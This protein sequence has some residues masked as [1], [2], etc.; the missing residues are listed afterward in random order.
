MRFVVGFICLGMSAW[1]VA[2]GGCLPLIDLDDNNRNPAPGTTLAVSVN[3]PTTNRTVPEGTAIAIRWLAVNRTGQGAVATISA[4]RLSDLAEQVIAGGVRVESNIAQTIDWDTTGVEAGEY[5]IRVRVDAGAQSKEATAEGRITIDAAPTFIFSA[6]TSDSTVVF[7]DPNDPNSTAESVSIRWRAF[8][9]GGSASAVIGLDPDTDHESGNEIEIHRVELPE[10]GSTETFSFSGDDIDD[11]AVPA[12]TYNLYAIAED[13]LNA[14]VIVNGLARIIVPER[15]E[16][17]EPG[18]LAITEPEEDVDSLVNGDPIEIKFTLDEPNDV[19]VDLRLDSDANHANGN[20]I[21]I[22]SQMLVKKETKSESFSWNGNDS[23]GAPVPHGIYQV[24]IVVNTGSALPKTADS[25]ARVLRR[26]NDRQPLIAL[27]TPNA[28]TQV[29]TGQFVSISWRDEDPDG[30]A[31][32][33]VTIDDDAVPN[34]TT[35]TGEPEIVI[36]SGRAAAG[37]GVEDTFLYQIPASLQPGTYHIF[38]YIRKPSTIGAGQIS[39]AG[40]RLIVKDPNS[41]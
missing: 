29:D 23:S 28:T 21:T 2:G 35:E 27:L 5:R 26:L 37:D 16:I 24:V 12:G 34:E 40:G 25:E 15:P 14:K 22:L 20:E 9:A 17:P 32:I 31:I 33:R 39:A 36:L 4:T 30:D 7:A 6:P 38:A 19:L 11:E 41:P 10:T 13:S 8:D 1:L 3:T 18:E